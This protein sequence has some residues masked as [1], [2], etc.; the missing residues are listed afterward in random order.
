MAHF[1]EVEHITKAYP[2]EALGA[3]NAVSFT[4]KAGE[5]ISFVGE[6]GS[7]KSTLLRLVAGLLKPDS[8]RI[9]FQG[10]VLAD[11]EEQLIAGHE[12]I[13]MVFQ[14]YALMPN[15]TVKENLNY[16]LLDYD[17]AYREERVGE[18]LELCNISAFGHKKPRDL[19]GGQQQRLA[20]AR[21]LAGE[22]ELLLMDEPFSSLDP[23]N[24]EAL[25]REVL[26]IVR[27]EEVGLIF[28]T[29]DTADALMISDRVGFLKQGAL[30]QMDTPSLIYHS[31]VSLEVGAFF[32]KINQIPVAILKTKSTAKMNSAKPVYVRM[33]AL[34]LARAED[35]FHFEVN[36]KACYFLGSQYLVTG[37]LANGSEVFFFHAKAVDIQKKGLKLSFS[38]ENRLE[39]EG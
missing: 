28:V 7:G 36:P 12:G 29:H 35:D 5:V 39:F 3:V 38:A 19:S 37:G 9:A 25:L 18:L 22:P 34:Q 14:D 15:M 1:L 27:Q 23:V 33:E 24:K 17:K 32:G 31:P 26:Q 30:L 13:K 11:P 10:E 16:I 4:M 21:A 6:S 20:L 2:G 8:G